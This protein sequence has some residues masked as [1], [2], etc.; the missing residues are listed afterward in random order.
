MRSLCTP[1]SAR[2]CPE[3]GPRGA[4]LRAAPGA[5]PRAGSQGPGHAHWAGGGARRRAMA[6]RGR[7]ARCGSRLFPWFGGQ[8]LQATSLG[9]RCGDPQVGKAPGRG[10]DARPRWRGRN[11]P[12]GPWAAEAAASRRRRPALLFR[13]EPLRRSGGPQD[14][15]I[16]IDT[17]LPG[18]VTSFRAGRGP[19]P[20]SCPP[21][22]AEGPAWGQ[23]TSVGRPRGTREV[24]D[25]SKR[26]RAGKPR[27]P[28]PR[29]DAGG[30]R[31][32]PLARPA[33][34]SPNRACASKERASPSPGWA[35]GVTK[36]CG[37]FR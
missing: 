10:P 35:F 30:G 23:A 36:P 37:G 28:E 32:G 34:R 18:A 7:P 2:G 5:A 31:T 17:L 26:T 27:R 1:R 4:A 11:V 16:P 21:P 19:G 8:R 6:P 9:P 33:P 3:G 29:P 13:S 15:L 14:S 22:C 12:P 25:M 20:S 24:G